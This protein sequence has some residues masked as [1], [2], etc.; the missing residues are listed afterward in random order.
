MAFSIGAYVTLG[1]NAMAH[2]LAAHWARDDS[3]DHNLTSILGAS[4]TTSAVRAV[5]RAIFIDEA[6]LAHALNKSS[7][8]SI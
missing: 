4:A 7:I 5:W 8:S 1:T 6:E 3:H 2:A